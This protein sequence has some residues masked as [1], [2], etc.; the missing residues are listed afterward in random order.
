MLSSRRMD[1]FL[2]FA[3]RRL[4]AYL[5]GALLAWLAPWAP[6]LHAQAER[7][8]VILVSIDGFRYDYA[9]R[10]QTKNILAVRDGGASAESIIPSFPSLTFPNHISIATGLYPEHHG[11]VGN[12]F[13]D[14]ARDGEFTLRASSTEGPWMDP[15]ATPLWVLAEQQHLIAACMFWPMCDSEIRGVRPA[16]WKLYDDRFPDEQRVQQVL[17]WLKLPPDRR[18]HFITLYFSGVDHA[19]HSFGPDAPET[20]QAAKWVDGMIGKLRQGLD[21]LGLPVNLVLV[22]DHG[23]QAVEGEVSLGIN[24]PLARVAI[25]GPLA[26]IY[27]RNAETID[28]I[29]QQLKKNSKLEVYKRAE[30]PAAWHYRENPRSGDLVA[31]A[32]GRAILVGDEPRR[33]DPPKGMHGYDPQQDKQMQGIFYAIGPNIKPMKIASFENVNVY[34]FIA[35]ILGLKVTGKLDGSEAVLDPIYQ[36]AAP[37][38]HTAAVGN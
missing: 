9:Q 26:L 33:R 3:R 7:P 36:Q 10:F 4:P 19:G 31:I 5:A 29:Y 14:P 22:S 20:A 21:T 23:M 16:Y 13:Y 6:A 1:T 2:R 32:K 17:D 34:P 11:I 35:K 8:Y 24:E 38:S 30:T 27:C 25:D 15:R 18:P 12:S 28:K 37:R